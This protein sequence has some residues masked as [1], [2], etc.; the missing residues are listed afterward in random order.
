VD[1]A[2][3]MR[4]VRGQFDPVY[5]ARIAALREMM[6]LAEE[7]T[8]RGRGEVEG[9]YGSLAEDYERLAP[10]ARAQAEDFRQ[11]TEDLYGQL[12]S[13]IEGSYSRIQEEQ[14]DLFKQLGIEAAAPD[15]LEPQG[16]QAARAAA[17][18]ET[19]GTL[20][21]QRESEVGRLESAY[22]KEGA[23]LATLTGSNMSAEMLQNLEDYLRMREQD[24]TMAEAER[25]SGIQQAYTQLLMQAQGQAQQQERW[26]QEQLFRLLQGQMQQGQQ[27]ESPF[28][29]AMSDVS[30]PDIF[31]QYLPQG[32]G[33]QFLD[34][35][36]SLMQ[37][38]EVRTGRQFIGQSLTDYPIPGD[39]VPTTDAFMEGLV[40][41]MLSSGAISPATAG[42]LIQFMRMRA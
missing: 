31:A 23:P 28:A 22:W 11:Q 26:Q 37:T 35:W 27:V 1:E 2:D 9:M 14:G 40:Q 4:Q 30:N 32:Q 29:D 6:G 36:N 8:T 42:Q 5:D 3:L 21:Q 17:A 34:A 24:I 38:P 13:N 19:F 7:R 15:V 12:R 18:A 33:Q 16:A 39:V 10:E 20:A 41:E 25:S